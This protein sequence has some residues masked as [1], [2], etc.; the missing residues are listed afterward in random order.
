MLNYKKGPNEIFNAICA[1]LWSNYL[2]WI[3]PVKMHIA[4][5][6][7]AMRPA[8][9]PFEKKKNLDSLPC[10]QHKLIS[11]YVCIAVVYPFS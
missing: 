9:P 7:T 10:I 5:L 4:S 6:S 3:T 11:V 2:I 8:D 1:Q